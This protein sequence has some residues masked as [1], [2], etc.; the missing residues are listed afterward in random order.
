MIDFNEAATKP[1]EIISFGKY[2][3]QPIEIL[4]NDKE[5][6]DWLCKQSWFREKFQGIH[7]LIVNNFNRATDTPDHNALQSRFLDDEFCKKTMELINPG[8]WL[9]LLQELKNDFDNGISHLAVENRPS[10]FDITVEERVFAEFEVRGADVEMH[11]SLRAT[12]SFEIKRYGRV[13]HTGGFDQSTRAVRLELKPQVSDD[14]PSVLRQMKT[15]RCDVLVTRAYT[16]VGAT[17]EQFRQMF[18]RSNIVVLMENEIDQ[19]C[20]GF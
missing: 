12:K 15:S 10:F 1:S 9:R 14:F 16:G 5:Y 6:A 11:C 7:T 8:Y 13:Y 3:D 17:E 20:R 2:K 19:V 4:A 18:L